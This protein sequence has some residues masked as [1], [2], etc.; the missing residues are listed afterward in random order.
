[1]PRIFNNVINDIPSSGHSIYITQLDTFYELQTK[2]RGGYRVSKTSPTQSYSWDLYA[3]GFKQL[4]RLTSR[5]PDPN[6]YWLRFSS[7]RYFPLFCSSFSDNGGQ[8]IYEPLPNF[9]GLSLLNH[10]KYSGYV[11]SGNFT[12]SPLYAVT[13]R[14]I[15]NTGENII[16]RASYEPML[17]IM[18]CSSIPTHKSFGPA[19]MNSFTISVDGSNSLGD[20]EINCSITGGRVIISPQNVPP[21]DHYLDGNV[22]NLATLDPSTKIFNQ[23]FFNNFGDKFRPVNLSNCLFSFS[24]HSGEFA[25]ENFVKTVRSSYSSSKMPIHKI[26]SMSLSITQD[27]NF[28]FTYPGFSYLKRTEE[29]GDITGPRFA[30]L[31]TRRVTGSLKLFSPTNYNFINS[32]ASSLTMYFGSYYFYSMKNVDWQQPVIN[33]TPGGGYTLEYNFTAR[34]TEETYFAGLGNAKMS[35]FTLL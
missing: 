25:F 6:Y 29:F 30:N 31:G 5:I 19:F 3:L 21:F 9:S 14:N 20:V 22:I 4:N 13:G 24:H 12:F 1:M 7:S 8:N 26:I 28:I 10:P 35:E 32:N 27:V 16:Y 34:M 15:H 2:F 23:E 17:P 11:Y 33:I 18:V